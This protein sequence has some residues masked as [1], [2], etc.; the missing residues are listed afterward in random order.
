VDLE[1]D[2]RGGDDLARFAEIGVEKL[3]DGCTKGRG[4]RGTKG[5][6]RGWSWWRERKMRW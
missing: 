1:R 5:G 4:Q 2:V 3:E 6:Y